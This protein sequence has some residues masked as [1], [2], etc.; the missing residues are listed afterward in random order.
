MPYIRRI[1]L[2]CTCPGSSTVQ[3]GNLLTISITPPSELLSEVP[4]SPSPAPPECTHC[5][6][7]SEDSSRR[8]LKNGHIRLCVPPRQR[9]SLKPD[10]SA[11]KGLHHTIPGH[12]TSCFRFAVA[13]ESVSCLSGLPGTRARNL[14]IPNAVVFSVM[15]HK[16]CDTRECS[17]S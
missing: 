16:K 6:A 2:R 15:S 5:R 13:A 11:T 1:L 10:N 7:Y 4:L 9:L 3:S 12:Q 17:C 14:D 8:I